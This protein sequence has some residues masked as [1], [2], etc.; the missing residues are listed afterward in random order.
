MNS[1]KT[2][3]ALAPVDSLGRE[4]SIPARDAYAL[5]QAAEVRSA[6]ALGLVARGLVLLAEDPVLW[7]GPACVTATLATVLVEA[8][9]WLAGGVG[10]LPGT[11][12]RAI[13][14]GWMATT[15][16]LAQGLL[17][18]KLRSPDPP[19][20]TRA[21]AFAAA[22][23]RGIACG[24][25]PVA[26]VFALIEQ[27]VLWKLLPSIGSVPYL[28]YGAHAAWTALMVAAFLPLAARL[29]W[30]SSGAGDGNEGA[31]TGRYLI[32]GFAAP[33]L[34]GGLHGLLDIAASL[35]ANELLGTVLR[36]NPFVDPLAPG[37]ILPLWITLSG[38]L[39][40]VVTGVAL[41]LGVVTLGLH[42][43]GE[44]G[45]PAPLLP[46]VVREEGAG[47]APLALG[48]GVGTVA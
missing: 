37:T 24:I 29:G 6:S 9:G 35:G 26:V 17:V 20:L 48:E 44:R 8:G 12:G 47:A 31:G 4:L 18:Q 25:L 40:E 22:R 46:E 1:K 3:G 2:T 45:P 14:V 16:V 36:Q 13:Q 23:A 42:H 10:L 33:F 19:E 43:L 27:D 32:V 7:L 15:A 28:T 38:F 11:F 34:V 21:I 30:P 5:H 41:T 39:M